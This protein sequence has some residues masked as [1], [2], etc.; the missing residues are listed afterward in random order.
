MML[1]ISKI[2]LLILVGLWALIGGIGNFFHIGSGYDSVADVLNPQNVVGLADWQRIENPIAV[3]AAWSII[4]I[5][6]L[7]AAGLIFIGSWQMWGTRHFGADKFNHTKSVALAGCAVAIAMLFG[8]FI[9]AAE[10]YFLA[11]Q[12]EL[13][14]LALPVAFRYIGCIALIAI[15]VQQPDV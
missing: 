5:S 4:P 7:A 13:G 10:T 15:F 9:V 3:W 8:G 11:W 14:A 6:K 2:V 12:T 1:R